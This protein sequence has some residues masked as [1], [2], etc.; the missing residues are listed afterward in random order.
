MKINREKRFREIRIKNHLFF[1]NTYRNDESCNNIT[2][3]TY[4]VHNIKL[5]I[6]F[7]QNNTVLI[8][9]ITDKYYPQ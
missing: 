9:I 8:F 5:Y 3:Y 6:F 1:G 2:L 7:L 4:Q